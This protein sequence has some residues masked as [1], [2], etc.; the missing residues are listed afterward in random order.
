M[1]SLCKLMWTGCGYHHSAEVPTV[2]CVR[3]SNVKQDDGSISAFVVL[4]L[5]D[6][7]LEVGFCRSTRA[8]K[9]ANCCASFVLGGF[10][11]SG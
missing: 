9:A 1:W 2:L 7:L 10:M 11:L 5:H 4:L 6:Q 3:L 8:D